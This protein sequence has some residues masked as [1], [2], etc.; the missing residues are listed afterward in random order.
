MSSG[1]LSSRPRLQYA[2]E[3][4]S[5]APPLTE[6]TNIRRSFEHAAELQFD[7]PQHL[8]RQQAENANDIQLRT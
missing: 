8:R 2:F 4:T 3:P 5:I 6:V 1:L 7:V